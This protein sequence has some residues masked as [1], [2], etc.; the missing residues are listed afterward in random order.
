V[1]CPLVKN[2]EKSGLK[3]ELKSVRSRPKRPGKGIA[4]NK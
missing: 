2:G 3:S 1:K 4:C